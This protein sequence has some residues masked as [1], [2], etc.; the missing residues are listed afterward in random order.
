MPGHPMGFAHVSQASCLLLLTAPLHKQGQVAEVC[1]NAWL[2]GGVSLSFLQ[3]FNRQWF[4]LHQAYSLVTL[5]WL[6]ELQQAG[7]L[8]Q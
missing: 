4:W 3:G 7:T 2:C 6:A 8:Y 1:C 5:D